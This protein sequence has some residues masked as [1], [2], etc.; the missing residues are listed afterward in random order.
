MN[1][2]IDIGAASF[3]LAGLLALFGAAVFAGCQAATAMGRLRDWNRVRKFTRHAIS[4]LNEPVT[5]ER[6]A[7]FYVAIKAGELRD[8]LPGRPAVPAASYRSCSEDMYGLPKG[9]AR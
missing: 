8:V 3:A 4:R 6:A 5:A 9:G 7:A 2:L 1:A